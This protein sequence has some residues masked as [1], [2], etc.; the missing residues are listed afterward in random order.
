MDLFVEKGLETV[1]LAGAIAVGCS[2]VASVV[3]IVSKSR[4]QRQRK[5]N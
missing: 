4:Q 5:A 2:L 3:R 1:A